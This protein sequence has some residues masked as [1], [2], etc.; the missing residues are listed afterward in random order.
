KYSVYQENN[1]NRFNYIG[2]YRIERPDLN[3]EEE[4]VFK[5][6]DILCFTG[7]SHMKR[8]HGLKLF[9]LKLLLNCEKVLNLTEYI[10]KMFSSRF[11]KKV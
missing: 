5:A 10:E 2:K 6:L 1:F 9:P 3:T 4:A 8:G 7:N 11:Q